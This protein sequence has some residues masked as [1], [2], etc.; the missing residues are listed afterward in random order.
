[1]GAAQ[2]CALPADLDDGAL[3]GQQAGLAVA[4]GAGDL[5]QNFGLGSLF[6]PLSLVDRAPFAVA[7]CR[8]GSEPSTHTRA[9][10][11]TLMGT[12]YPGMDDYFRRS[13]FNALSLEGTQVTSW[14]SIG[15]R[16]SYR[17]PTGSLDGFRI[18][19]D[20]IAQARQELNLSNFEH[21]ML[22][23]N[24]AS[25]N[26]SGSAAGT[27][28]SSTYHPPFFSIDSG[29]LGH[30]AQLAREIAEELG[31]G[32]EPRH[33]MNGSAPFT[34]LWDGFNFGFGNDQP[35]VRPIAAHMEQM[36]WLP[37]ARVHTPTVPGSFNIQLE[38]AALPGSAKPIVAKIPTGPN[39]YYTVEVRRRPEEADYDQSLVLEGVVIHDV[40]LSSIYST[41]ATLVDENGGDPN[42]EGSMWTP[43]ET[44]SGTAGVTVNVQSFS[45]TGADVRIN[46]PGRKLTI[47]KQNDGNCTGIVQTVNAPTAASCGTGC[48]NY[49][50]SVGSVT[51]RAYPAENV[52]FDGWVGCTGSTISRTCTVPMTA[53][54]TVTAK[55]KC[56]YDCYGNCFD[57]CTAM[58]QLPSRCVGQCR[59]ECKDE[60]GF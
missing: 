18:A 16:E 23:I 57:S 9:T 27:K 39:T 47:K 37:A 15:A 26:V 44:F 56:D 14:R 49:L 59:A 8:F 22:V 32:R 17:T 4:D 48:S 2:A 1:M 19:N 30:P 50:M 45:G 33:A 36:G 54:R 11:Q 51:L 31:Q 60:E 3:A 35:L 46:V 43:G 21:A 34:S 55:F 6:P 13:S 42:D 29:N 7:L 52:S 28:G 25:V 40:N 38:R 53:D 20:C 24:G 41:N 5:T 58:G 10:V 12:S